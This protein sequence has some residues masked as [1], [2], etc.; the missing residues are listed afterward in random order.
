MLNILLTS[1]EYPPY[2][3]WG[4]LGTHS[5]LLAEGLASAGH[6]V[7]VLTI[8]FRTTR[9][10]Q[11]NGVTV[12]LNDVRRYRDVRKPFT[13]FLRDINGALASSTPGILESLGFTPSIIH[14]QASHL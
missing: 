2:L 14:G 11:R 10:E 5:N 7:V 6:R 3:H 8:D 12:I 1:F 4:G 13:E 9:V